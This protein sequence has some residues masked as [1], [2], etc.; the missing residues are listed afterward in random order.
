MSGEPKRVAV[1]GEPQRV[2]GYALAGAKVF[3]CQGTAAVRDAWDALGDD[4]AVVALTPAAAEALA[5]HL[6][7]GGGR[8]RLMVVLP[9]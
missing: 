2:R 7:P 9:V 1:I 8:R 4:V 6:R 5:G 3:E